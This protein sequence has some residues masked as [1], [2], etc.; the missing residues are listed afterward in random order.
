MCVCVC[1][2]ACVCACTCVS[3][4]VSVSLSV[5]VCVYL[6]LRACTYMHG[7]QGRTPRA[8]NGSHGSFESA[9]EVMVF[10]LLTLAIPA[11]NVWCA[12]MEVFSLCF[13]MCV[14]VSR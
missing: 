13:C 1:V 4:A 12:R 6:C 9:K 5:C 3:V 11:Q 10:Q 7:P 2:C 14:S 8:H